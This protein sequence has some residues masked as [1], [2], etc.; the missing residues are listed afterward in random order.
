MIK[1]I[2][3]TKYGVYWSLMEKLWIRPWRIFQ[4]VY[5][6]WEIFQVAEYKPD[7]KIQNGEINMIK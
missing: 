5:S 1:K 3:I 2:F 4:Y 7:K 6:N